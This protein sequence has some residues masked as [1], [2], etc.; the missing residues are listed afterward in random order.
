MTAQHLSDTRET[1]LVGRDLHS[2]LCMPRSTVPKLDFYVGPCWMAFQPADRA[3]R[4]T[5]ASIACEARAT[6]TI[7][8][9]NISRG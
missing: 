2:A 5:S 7:L 4:D 8:N 1:E 6:G 9:L 3:R